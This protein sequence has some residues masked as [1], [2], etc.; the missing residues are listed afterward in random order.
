MLKKRALKYFK[1]DGRGFTLIE[2]MIVVSII[3]ILCSLAIPNYQWGIIRAREAVLR[4]SLYNFRTTIDQFYAD[5][6]KYP[7]SLQEIVDKKYLRDIPA[8]PFTKSKESWVVVPPPQPT[9]GSEI[10][11]AVYDVHSG[12]DLIGSNEIPYNEW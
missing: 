5:Q 4:E 8:D 3:G 11:G 2:L 12:S 9:D 7:D 6:G 1:C 10:K